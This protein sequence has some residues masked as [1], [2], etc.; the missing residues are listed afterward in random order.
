MSPEVVEI[1]A[2][3]S[4]GESVISLRGLLRLWNRADYSVPLI[5][6]TD[7]AGLLLKR[8]SVPPGP[9][10]MPE[11]KSASVDRPLRN[12]AETEIPSSG[13]HLAKRGGQAQALIPIRPRID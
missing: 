1:P 11:E 12:S 4:S 10:R 2:A 13:C 7:S 6:T 9:Y 8:G 3:T 5:R